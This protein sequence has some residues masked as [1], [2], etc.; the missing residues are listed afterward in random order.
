MLCSWL[1]QQPKEEPQTNS[2]S[3]LIFSSH[4]IFKAVRFEKQFYL[5]TY[6]LWKFHIGS[7]LY[8]CSYCLS[9]KITSTLGVAYNASCGRMWATWKVGV[10]Y[11]WPVVPLCKIWNSNLLLESLFAS[12]AM[13]NQLWSAS[14]K[15]ELG[16]CKEH[17]RNFRS[18]L[19]SCWILKPM[20]ECH[21]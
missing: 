9:G 10:S 13:S 2:Y 3:Q 12:D 1:Q 15:A 6:I 17:V 11:S 4:V 21:C 8:F 14:P 16:E 5:W 20:R 7:F 19:L 18:F